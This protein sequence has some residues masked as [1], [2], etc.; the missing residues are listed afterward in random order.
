[1]TV[2]LFVPDESALKKAYEEGRI[3]F[4]YWGKVWPAAIALSRFIVQHGELVRG[5]KLVEIA[6]GLGLPSMVAA[7]V[8]ASVICSDYAPEALAVLQQTI[9]YNGFKNTSAALIDWHHLPHALAADVVLLSDVSYDPALFA[10]QQ[11]AV[12]KFLGAG[13]MVIIAT[14]QRLV[15]K[16]AIAPLLPY[17]V[18][19]QQV[20][21]Q[22]DGAEVM[23]SVMVLATS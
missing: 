5:K 20:P 3:S 10:V 17:A 2:R 13:A 16:E 9:A 8:A 23:I 19:Q 22:V 11:A 6:A 12:Q 15:A 18:M 1:M 21:V 4:P 14:P 7:P